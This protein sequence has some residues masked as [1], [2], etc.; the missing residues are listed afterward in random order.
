MSARRPSL[1]RDRSGAGAA[2][3]ALVL[4]VF[5]LMVMAGLQ[6]GWAQHTAGAMRYGLEQAAR[7]LVLDPTLTDSAI[8]AMIH[9]RVGATAAPEVTVSV[10]REAAGNG[11]VARI[12]AVFVHGVGLPGLASLPINFSRTVAAPL[13]AS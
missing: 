6:I 10:T 11:Q 7:A 5:T 13:P 3:F 4:P 12:T 2:E 9:E 8:R 1:W